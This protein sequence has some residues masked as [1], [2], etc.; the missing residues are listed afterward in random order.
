[1]KEERVVLVTGSATG[2]GAEIIRSF[3]AKGF[4]VVNVDS[5]IIAQAPR[6][7]SHLSKMSES[8]AGA[9]SVP[10]DLVNVKVKSAEALGA[11]GREEAIAAHAVCLIEEVKS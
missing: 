7:G 6:L 1:M 8:L 3:A 5:V 9:L 11:I 10:S 4:R 2:L